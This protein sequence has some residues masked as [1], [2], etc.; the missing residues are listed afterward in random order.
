M[1]DLTAETLEFLENSGWSSERNMDISAYVEAHKEYGCNVP[2]VVLEIL[3]QFNGLTIKLPFKQPLIIN[4]KET[5]LSSTL[6]FN[7]HLASPAD[8]CNGLVHYATNINADLVYP[9][10]LLD[11]ITLLLM[12]DEGNIYCGLDY[13]EI[14]R[15]G[16]TIA[17]ALNTIIVTRGKPRQV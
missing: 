14:Y 10:G 3:R 6:E 1:N 15:I 2:D 9:I 13:G 8:L 5:Y 7:G 17:E 12:D 16:R 4:N 11:G